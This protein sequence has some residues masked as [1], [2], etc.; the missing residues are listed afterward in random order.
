MIELTGHDVQGKLART[1][2]HFGRQPERTEGG[3]ALVEFALLSLP[4]F[5]ILFGTIEF[6]W[7]FFQ[8]N[9]IRHGA[10]EGIRLVA[11]NADPDPTYDGLEMD[12]QGERIAQAACERMDRKD[13]VTIDVTILDTDA[14]GEYDVGDD[15]TLVARKPLEQITNVFHT[16]LQHTVLDE[17]ITT[18]MEQDWWSDLPADST[19]TWDCQ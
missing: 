2:R 6:G 19:L 5:L 7:A 18:R 12:N 13:G 3:A 10:R 8:L 1:R 16:I 14:N 17:T 15:A 4:L 9:D 11:V